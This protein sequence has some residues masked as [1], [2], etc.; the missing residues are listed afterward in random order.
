M[1]TL[2]KNRRDKFKASYERDV[3]LRK[4][5][6]KWDDRLAFYKQQIY[7]HKAY[8]F[9]TNGYEC[10]HFD[11]LCS[12]CQ[13]QKIWRDAKQNGQTLTYDEFHELVNA[14]YLAAWTVEEEKWA[15]EKKRER[16]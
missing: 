11:P 7:D 5:W 2:S 6:R 10:F 12:L 13:T 15:E 4:A 8:N 3:T 9:D 16:Q 1:K 14:S